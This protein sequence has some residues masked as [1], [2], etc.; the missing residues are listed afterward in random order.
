[1]STHLGTHLDAP[2]HFFDAGRTVDQLDLSRGFGPAWVLDFSAKGAK[3][4]ITRDE[5]LKH[6]RL[7]LRGPV[8][9]CGPD[10]TRCFPNHATSPIF[11]A[12][13]PTHARFSPS[14]GSRASP[15]ICR[16]CT[17]PTTFRCITR[18]SAPRCSSWRVSRTWSDLQADKY[19]SPPCPF[20]SAAAMA[21]RAGRSQSTVCRRRSCGRCPA[22]R[23]RRR[24]ADDRRPLVALGRRATPQAIF[25]RADSFFSLTG[26]VPGV[27]LFD[28]K[29]NLPAPAAA[30]PSEIPI[31]SPMSIRRRPRDCDHS[32]RTHGP[33]PGREPLRQSRGAGRVGRRG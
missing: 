22:S 31:E 9:S 33:T 21:R 8:S 14:G 6:D 18:C 2:F 30:M 10:G 4:E 28:R 27:G 19:F 5:L 1:M 25:A 32:R 29:L 23:M 15:W 11:P 12:S 3:A 13:S 17:D 24:A 20:G 7:L 26:G 16:P